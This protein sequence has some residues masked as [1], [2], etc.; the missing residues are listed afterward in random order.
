MVKQIEENIKDF[1]LMF[2]RKEILDSL[3]GLQSIPSNMDKSV[4]KLK[5]CDSSLYGEFLGKV[6]ILQ[7][8]SNENIF[9]TLIKKELQEA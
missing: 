7:C 4:S 2:T 1:R 6:K 8:Q 9:D 3:N 5:K